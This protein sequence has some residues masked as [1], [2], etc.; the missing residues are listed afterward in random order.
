MTNHP[1]TLEEALEMFD[2]FIYRKAWHETS[3]PAHSNNMRPEKE[4]NCIYDFIRN[5]ASSFLKIVWHAGR[6][7][8]VDEVVDN[9]FLCVAYGC[10]EVTQMHQDT[11]DENV[12][13]NT[14][15]ASIFKK[16]EALRKLS[17]LKK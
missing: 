16:L 2:E 7:S 12:A 4:C 10:A 6:K 9:A 1:K 8:V 17:E 13:V 3:C 5:E 11:S 14:A 15:R